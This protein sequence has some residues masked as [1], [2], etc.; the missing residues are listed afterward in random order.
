[1]DPPLR[2]EPLTLGRVRIDFHQSD[3]AGVN[4]YGKCD[5][6]ADWVLLASVTQTPYIDNRPL[7]VAGQPEQRRYRAGLVVN[8]AAAGP[9]TNEIVVTAEP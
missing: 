1:L 7:W 4:I 8:A 9:F 3:S 5:G 2:G 6:E